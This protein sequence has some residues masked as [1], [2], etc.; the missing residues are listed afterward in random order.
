MPSERLGGQASLAVAR[1]ANLRRDVV[2]LFEGD[3]GAAEEAIAE[4]VEE[5]EV[6]TA[7]ATRMI[8]RGDPFAPAFS[9][10]EVPG[11]MRPAAA[12]GL[13]MAHLLESWGGLTREHV[14][15]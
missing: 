3:V 1:T 5:P 14:R 9:W 13:A 2:R 15:G 12:R 11:P 10:D 7:W 8:R 4:L 6:L